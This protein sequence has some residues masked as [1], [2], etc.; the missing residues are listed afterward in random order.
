MTSQE[1]NLFINKYTYF[2]IVKFFKYFTSK[3]PRRIYKSFKQFYLGYFHLIIHA[4][5]SIW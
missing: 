1:H 4:L 5:Q 2:G 3:I